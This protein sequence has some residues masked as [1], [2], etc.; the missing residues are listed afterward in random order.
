MRST[1]DDL[2]TT[3]AGGGAQPDLARVSILGGDRQI[4]VALP[5]GAPIAAL[6]P[7][8]LAH[9]RLPPVDH[10][11]DRV[12]DLPRWTLARVGG[13]PLPAAESL[14]A[15]GV[16]DGDLLVVHPDLPTASGAVVD[17]VV[18]GVAHL[19][20][21]RSPAWSPDAA[22]RLGYGI[23]VVAALLAAAA[24]R[25]IGPATVA[26]PA[27]AAGAAVLLSVAAILAGRLGADPRS[28]CTLS[29]CGFIACV[30]AGSFIPPQDSPPAV[31]AAAGACGLTCALIVHRSTGIGHRLHAGLATGGAVLSVTGLAALAVDGS[32]ARGAAIGAT[33]A[34]FTVALAARI[35]LAASHLPLP[36]V[37]A[38]PAPAS[39]PDD[40][41]PIP[42][43]DAL[44]AVDDPVVAIADLALTDLEVLTRRSAIASDYLDGIVVAAACAA[45]AAVTVVVASFDGAVASSCFAAV[46]SLALVARGRTH[47]DRV[48]ATALIGS[49]ALGLLVVLL[50]CGDRIVGFVGAI[51]VAVAAFVV[52]TVAGDLRFSPLQRRAGEVVDLLVIGSIVP[53]LLWLL[54][55]YRLVRER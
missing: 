25:L 47:L 42:G 28:V 52:G 16:F 44:P 36:P 12:L 46:V 50:G 3:G 35:A 29:A 20:R 21:S 48:Q 7:D 30:L 49:G 31:G 11:P 13:A 8:V 6:M 10:D 17:D 24:G 39:D 38:T 54:D 33:V 53:L 55:V 4:D 34:V 41:Q 19:T 15:A 51:G 1:T 26:V 27:A 18:D 40:P 32:L 5:A 2:W 45:L 22:R 9:L 43:V 37:P 14:A 23:C